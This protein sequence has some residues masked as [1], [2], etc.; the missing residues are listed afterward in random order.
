MIINYNSGSIH[1]NV[2]SNK[3]MIN[4]CYCVDTR[5]NFHNNSQEGRSNQDFY[6][7]IRSKSRFT[8]DLGGLN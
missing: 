7:L 4:R 8:E 2:K 5:D 3:L 6:K 1:A